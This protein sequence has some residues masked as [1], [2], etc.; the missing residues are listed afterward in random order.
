MHKNQTVD[1]VKEK[2]IKWTKFDKFRMN[3]MDALKKL[4][5]IIDESDPDG[6][7]VFII[8]IY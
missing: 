7:S 4:N 3:I 2:I 8:K 5:E 1:F 6:I